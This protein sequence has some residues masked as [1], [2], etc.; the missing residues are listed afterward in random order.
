MAT[1]GTLVVSLEA[2]IARF[3]SA[4]DSAVSQAEKTTSQITGVVGN[5]NKVLGLIGVTIS[6]ARIVD[7]GKAAA[8]FGAQMERAA[9]RT[10]VDASSFTTLAGAAQLVN[11]DVDQLSTSF[12]KMQTAISQA[13]TGSSKALEA[14]TALGIKFDEFRKLSPEQQFLTIADRISMLKDPADRV[15][16]A[17]DLF[18]RAG[19]DLL[20]MFEKGATGIRQAREEIERLGGKLGDEQIGKLAQAEESIRHLDEAWKNF[21]R[22]LTAAV[23]PALSTILEKL[24]GGT[25]DQIAASLGFQLAKLADF[26]ASG[27]DTKAIEARVAELRQQLSTTY[28]YSGPER[29]TNAAAS[30]ADVPGYVGS[31][32]DMSG[33]ASKVYEST[34]TAA[35]KYAETVEKLTSALKTGALNQ[36]TFNRGLKQAQEAYADAVKSTDL[37]TAANLRF[38]EAQKDLAADWQKYAQIGVDFQKQIATATEYATEISK[39]SAAA[40]AKIGDQ[41]VKNI[42]KINL[43]GKTMTVFAEQAARNMQTSFAQFLFDPFAEGIRGM[44]K[45]FV[46][47]IRKMVAEIM[48]AQILKAL[49]GGLGDMFG[50]GLGSFFGSMAG[51]FG[52][53]L[54]SGGPAT[55]GT[56]Y[57]VGENGPEL[58]VPGASGTIMPNSALA[59]GG[60]TLNYTIDARGAD[61]SRIMAMLPPLLKQTKDQAVAEI[62]NL[63]GRGRL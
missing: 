55:G 18:G 43:S 5:I 21:A 57:L 28:H 12:K 46:D 47:M 24:A 2:N 10:G 38:Y 42:D 52:G 37:S 6:V 61:A 15:R 48:A 58:F 31:G 17:V 54:A 32:E 62:R 11:I 56:P 33:Y 41:A 45:G 7:A 30:A 29:R 13:G 53:G 4:L 26:K 25:Q 34:R 1:I 39:E 51:S 22:T 40:L 35:E 9:S 27:M 50:G 49:F 59:G 3:T 36:D 60:V 23:A 14:F 20:P 19:A 16:A 44:L 63:R 8:E